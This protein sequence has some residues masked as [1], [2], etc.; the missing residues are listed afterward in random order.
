MMQGGHNIYIG[1]VVKVENKIKRAK[2]L[3]ALLLKLKL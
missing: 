3:I 2:I 1:P